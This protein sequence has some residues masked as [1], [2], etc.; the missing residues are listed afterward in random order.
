M[1]LESFVS[2]NQL[3]NSYGYAIFEK[4]IILFHGSP[5]NFEIINNNQYFAIDV[6]LAGH[7][8]YNRHT[9]L[10]VYKT[11][12]PIKLL[13]TFKYENKRD[14]SYLKN[15]ISHQLNISDLKCLCEINGI[16]KNRQL[17]NKLCDSLNNDF[18]GILS[19]Y[20]SSHTYEIMLF[21][22]LEC[23]ELIHNNQ[24]LIYDN[25]KNLN[26]TGK[27]MTFYIPYDL[28]FIVSNDIIVKDC[29]CDNKKWYHKIFHRCNTK[30]FKIE[31]LYYKQIFTY[32]GTTI[33]KI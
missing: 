13:L 17:M 14:N 10:Y 1:S 2:S 3:I 32:N 28:P 21:K 30:Y 19:L 26:D 12:K 9:H 31:Y 16:K 27:F 20:D 7:G 15:V 8:G 33:I 25:C 4:D 5:Y 29:I 23:T 18:D 6:S 24:Y 11:I 22:P